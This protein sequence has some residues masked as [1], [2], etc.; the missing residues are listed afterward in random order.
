[1]RLPALVLATLLAA[2]GAALAGD[3]AAQLKFPEAPA[4]D[5]D[6]V[7]DM[8]LTG[9]IATAGEG[10]HDARRDAADGGERRLGIDVDPWVMPVF[11]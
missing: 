3:E 9:A 2:T 6:T 10:T 4:A 11:H 1:M 5:R 8:R 7:L